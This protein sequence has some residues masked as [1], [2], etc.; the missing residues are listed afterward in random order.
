MKLQKETGFRTRYDP[1][2]T[3]HDGQEKFAGQKAGHITAKT[4]SGSKSAWLAFGEMVLY[5]GMAER[6]NGHETP[7]LAGTANTSLLALDFVTGNP[8]LR[9]LAAGKSWCCCKTTLA[10]HR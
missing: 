5:P 2:S 8:F 10:P 9:Q 6:M 3:L 4:V 7:P 1:V